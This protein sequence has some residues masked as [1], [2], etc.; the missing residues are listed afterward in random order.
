MAVDRGRRRVGAASATLSAGALVFFAAGTG[1]AS[2][3]TSTAA[4]A[5]ECKLGTLL[6][7][8]LGA[9]TGT[10]AVPPKTSAPAKPS[11]Q[12]KPAKPKARPAPRP[13]PA[14][15]APREDSPEAPPAAPPPVEG[16]APLPES[17][18]QIPALP[19]VS[20]QDPVVFPEAAPGGRSVRPVAATSPDEPPVPPLLVAT[21]SGLIGSVAALNLSVAGHRRR[22]RRQND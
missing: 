6:C 13:K 16:A 9:G 4:Q 2:A 5:A 3:Q 22:A 18:Q 11:S 17:T 21:A 14:P 7:K 20:A 12:P 8:I 1:T 10:P 19:D 15:A